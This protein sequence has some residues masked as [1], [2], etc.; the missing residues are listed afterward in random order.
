MGLINSGSVAVAG[1][2][3]VA[4]TSWM[5]R[6]MSAD[7]FYYQRYLAPAVPLLIVGASA[8]ASIALGLLVR[9]TRRLATHRA[10]GA[11]RWGAGGIAA[12]AVAA[13]ISGLPESA[14]RFEVDVAAIDAV[15]VAMGRFIAATVPAGRVVWS[16][17]AGAIRYWS[18]RV[19]VDL[20]MLNTP[21]LFRG[22]EVRP[23]Y[24]ADT[25]VVLDGPIHVA[26]S[27]GALERVQSVRDPSQPPPPAAAEFTQVAWRCRAG[28]DGDERRIAI[29]GY[30]EARTGWCASR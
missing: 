4:A 1:I 15:Q 6:I 21:D 26:S 20:G 11:L 9:A 2:G 8:G 12:W 7:L 28:L 27:P 18:E 22:G 19:V 17:D 25:I 14:R 23:E 29:E 10:V 24:A 16:M 5:I 3:Y 13:E 30:P